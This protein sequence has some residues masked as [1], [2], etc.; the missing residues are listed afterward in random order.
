MRIPFE[1]IKHA[2]RVAKA[3]HKQCNCKL[4]IVQ[5]KLA[6]ASGYRDWHELSRVVGLKQFKEISLHVREMSKITLDLSNA[7]KISSGKVLHALTK[8]KFAQNSFQDNG[9]LLWVR[10]FCFR[11]QEIPYI[12][13]FK[14][15]DERYVH[16]LESSLTIR[17]DLST[18]LV[19]GFTNKS[20]AALCADSELGAQVP[21]VKTMFSIPIR[22]YLP[23]GYYEN[24]FDETIIFSRD[25]YPLWKIYYDGRPPKRLTPVETVGRQNFKYFWGNKAINWNNRDWDSDI[26]DLMDEYKITGLPELIEVLPTAFND[27][28]IRTVRDAVEQHFNS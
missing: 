21:D 4:S 10:G 15:G 2:K 6:K 23:Y 18:N 13:A 3:L 26:L 7:L 14:K 24:G 1:S 5:E 27:E 9:N 22:M 12:G 19:T 28:K 8:S 17:D 16:E 20:L 25:Y 11:K